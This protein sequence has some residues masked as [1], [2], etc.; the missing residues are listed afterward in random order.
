METQVSLITT[1]T[2]A[3]PLVFLILTCVIGGGAAW[4]AGRALALKWRAFWQVLV[5]MA[6]LAGAVRFLHHALFG[7]VF[8]SL[9]Y[10][11]VAYAVLLAAAGL[12]YRATRVKQMIT[13]YYWLYERAGPLTWREKRSSA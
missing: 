7:E 13:Q 2:G 4:L 11:L 8:V 6:L 10:Y 5:Y 12:G 9:Q 3:R 1:I